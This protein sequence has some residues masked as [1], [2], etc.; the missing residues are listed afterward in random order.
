LS[1]LIGGTPFSHLLKTAIVPQSPTPTNHWPSRLQAECRKAKALYLGI[2][3]IL[4]A[5]IERKGSDIP[6]SMC[7]S[8]IFFCF[9]LVVPELVLTADEAVDVVLPSRTC[10]GRPS[11]KPF[12]FCDPSSPTPEF[13][14]RCKSQKKV[15]LFSLA[16]A[17]IGWRPSWWKIEKRM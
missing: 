1:G 13:S 10:R 7:C 5:L 15:L 9:A 3:T 11:G 6:R 8:F 2:S 16:A 4:W 17:R 14:R 12:A